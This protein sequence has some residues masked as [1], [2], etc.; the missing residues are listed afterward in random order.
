M[1]KI[2]RIIHKII[3]ILL[4]RQADASL[5]N[6]PRCAY[7]V[8]SIIFF[9]KMALIFLAEARSSQRKLYLFITKI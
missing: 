3:H 9:I 2:N 6:V 7:T 1:R 4:F 8:S 5:D